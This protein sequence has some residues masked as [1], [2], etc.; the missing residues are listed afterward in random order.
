MVWRVG[1][2]GCVVWFIASVSVWNRW[3]LHRQLAKI[4]HL[5]WELRITHPPFFPSHPDAFSPCGN[6]YQENKWLCSPSSKFIATLGQEPGRPVSEPTVLPTWKLT[7]SLMVMGFIIKVTNQGWVR[8]PSF[9]T[10]TPSA[11]WPDCCHSLHNANALRK[12]TPQR[13]KGSKTQGPRGTA[14]G[15][16]WSSPLIHQYYVH[17]VEGVV[18]PLDTQA[19][20]TMYHVVLRSNILQILGWQC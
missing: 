1:K 14:Q 2:E 6:W 4:M 8:P 19:A 18:R 20:A 9:T 16:C 13:R 17:K 5:W 3:K 10:T 7:P 15:R 11:G 12:T